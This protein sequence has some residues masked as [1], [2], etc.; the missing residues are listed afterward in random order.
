MSSRWVSILSRASSLEERRRRGFDPVD[1]EDAT[2]R[3][4]RLERWRQ[5]YQRRGTDAVERR[6]RRDGLDVDD[7]LAV[8]ADGTL[9]DVSAP[10]AWLE[11]LLEVS[12]TARALNLE[13]AGR[14]LE[15]HLPRPV[16]FQEVLAPFA[17]SASRRLGQDRERRWDSALLSEAARSVL[18][19]DL[20]QQLS[21]LSARVLMVDF[22]AYRASREP[23]W[24]RVL[25]GSRAGSRDWYREFV[26]W[27]LEGGLLPLF[28]EYPVLARLMATVSGLWCESTQEFLDRL[29]EDHALVAESLGS[30][31][32]PG[33]VTD[34][35]TGL[36][37]RHHGGRTVIAV[38]FAS[39]LRVVYKP[40][41]LA[42]EEWFSDFLEWLNRSDPRLLLKRVT[43][44]NRRTHGW[45]E[46]VESLPCG[47]PE[48]AARYYRRAGSL[49]A[50]IHALRGTDCHYENLIACGEWPVLV[51]AEMLV[52][53]ML[54]DP[55]DPP[56]TDDPQTAAYRQLAETVMGT[57]FLPFWQFRAGGVRFDMSA[58]GGHA[59]ETLAPALAWSD[60][61]TDA[62]RPSRESRPSGRLRN[63]PRLEEAPLTPRGHEDEIVQ[64]FREMYLS[65]MARREELSAPGGPLS[66]L[67]GRRFRFLLRPTTTYVDG[68]VE[69][70]RPS[71]LR[72]AADACVEGEA[73]GRDILSDPEREH[74]WPLFHEELRAL[75][76]LDVPHFQV[77][78]DGVDVLLPDGSALPGALRRSGL[79]L[80]RSRLAGLS[81]ADLERQVYLVRGAML[82]SRATSAHAAV[83]PAP[84]EAAAPAGPLHEAE[85]LRAVE[86]IATAL[87]A[88]AVRTPRNGATW[89]AST[90]HPAARRFRIQPVG[91]GLFDGVAGIALFLA[92]LA[93]H[94]DDAGCRRLAL[95]SLAPLRADIR[96]GDPRAVVEKIAW[97]NALSAG[98]VLYALVRV[99]RLLDDGDLLD[100]A[101]ALGRA[102]T[103]QHIGDDDQLDVLFGAAG[104]IFGFLALHQS[105]REEEALDKAV[106][107][108]RHLLDRRVLAPSGHRVWKCTPEFPPLTGFSHG[109][110]GIACALLRLHGETRD[111]SLLEAARE[112][113]AFE[114][115]AYLGELRNWPD[116]RHPQEPV[117]RCGR[118]WCHGAPG[119]G[120]ARLGGLAGIRDSE[121]DAEL[122]AAIAT[123]REIGV[124]AIDG[125]CCGNLGRAEFLF[126]AGTVLGRPEVVDCAT[127]LVSQV[128]ARVRERGWWEFLGEE[129]PH[130]A[131]CHPGFFQGEAGAG[132]ELL[133]LLEPDALPSVLRFE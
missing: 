89:I 13:A 93:R 126:S 32:D 88:L 85:V 57:V 24:A 130:A 40:K 12:E 119:I 87:D 43:V 26:A 82:S 42:A 22:R 129:F 71:L 2:R 68:I 34:L 33:K 90:Y 58:L 97:G 75:Q 21:R 67:T 7:A 108:G 6:L 79:D 132:Y 124:E 44:L 103:P 99:A 78:A 80:A 50:L 120:L 18:L 16:P 69:L 77:A 122:E 23:S 121:V 17:V 109:A 113:Y 107:C 116:Y 51:D 45:T 14:W 84:R 41:D 86:G 65:L 127:R 131:G 38:T 91:Y 128:L 112:A 19:R 98:T 47:S 46:F 8:L 100:D 95:D 118:T 59:R 54:V 9:R 49:L 63:G 37:D 48:A 36:S 76:R 27:H 106:R 31:R 104:A 111:A 81:A 3:D 125:L 74:L 10:P 1:G 11:T 114:R 60:V 61:N 73:L 101:A 96:A 70:L 4:R 133:R 55:D 115:S 30:G 28:E 117:P 53:P 123:T 64:G 52:Q 94:T 25:A 5:V 20:V 35:E 56:G 66:A 102:V 83:D 15:P 105:T 62:M 92:A 39:G 29:A 110:A 72:D